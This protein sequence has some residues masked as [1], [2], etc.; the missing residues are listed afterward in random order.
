MA[1]MTKVE[2]LRFDEIVRVTGGPA[3]GA[4]KARLIVVDDT[5]YVFTDRTGPTHTF[6]Y[7]TE[8][9]TYPHL[10]NAS[11]T[12]GTTWVRVGSSCTYTLAKCKIKTHELL[13]TTIATADMEA[14]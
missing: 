1:N 14:Q 2:G 12:D 5:G 11:G 6:T 9:A 10:R 13:A 7:D 3:K 4:V 8:S